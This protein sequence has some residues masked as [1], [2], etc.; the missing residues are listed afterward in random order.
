MGK[1]KIE[2]FAFFGTLLGLTREGKLISGDDD[3]DFYVKESFYEDVRK[4]ISFM[5]LNIDYSSVPNDT[6]HFIQVS[7]KLNDIE[8]R[9]DFYFYDS[10]SDEDFLL[11]PWNFF[12]N[13]NNKDKLLKI[14]K[15]L[16]FPLKKQDFLNHEISIPQHPKI[17][18]EYLYGEDWKTPKKKK[19]DYITVML[20]GRPLRIVNKGFFFRL[21]SRIVI[22]SNLN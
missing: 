3:V 21:L 19:L 10:S 20:G 14:P 11:E 17:V 15:P 22:K 7:G 4:M 13:P 6:N 9:V 1:I 18:C 16:I 12:G 5:G 8:I 2:H